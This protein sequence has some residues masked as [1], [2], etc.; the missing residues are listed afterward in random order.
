VLLDTIQRSSETYEWFENE[1]VH[2]V[3]VNP[4]TRELYYFK[5]GKFAPYEPIKRKINV[6]P[7]VT[8]L[9]EE[10][11]STENLPVYKLS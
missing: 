7:D 8:R 11:L 6:M 1:W 9:V 4:E 5:D 10:S 3:A 2:L